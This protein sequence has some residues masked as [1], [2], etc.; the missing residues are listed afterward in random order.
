MEYPP[1]GLV[2]YATLDTNEEKLCYWNGSV[3]M[4]GVDNNPIDIELV[5]NVVSWRE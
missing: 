3:W 4:E 1:E 2:V 5:G